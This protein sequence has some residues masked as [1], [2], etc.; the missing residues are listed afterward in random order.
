MDINDMNLSDK[1]LDDIKIMLRN[2]RD[3]GNTDRIPSPLCT[4]EK[5]DEFY[6]EGIDFRDDGNYIQAKESFKIARDI[7]NCVANF[8]KAQDAQDQI[9]QLG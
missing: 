7:Y 8:K 6:E 4:L 5:G 2:I 1:S 9:D 3:M